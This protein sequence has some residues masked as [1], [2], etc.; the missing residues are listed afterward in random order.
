MDAAHLRFHVHGSHGVVFQKLSWTGDTAS[1]IRLDGYNVEG[2]MKGL[3]D[4]HLDTRLI[5][6]V[7]WVVGVTMRTGIELVVEQRFTV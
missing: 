2:V 3:F 7:F 5:F 6:V 4:G 1:D